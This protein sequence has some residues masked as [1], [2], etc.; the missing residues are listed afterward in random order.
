M[1][2]PEGVDTT[3]LAERLHAEGVLIE[4]GRP[5]LPPRGGMPRHY[6]LAYSSIPA[7]RIGEG[8]PFWPTRLLKGLVWALG[9]QNWPY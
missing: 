6:R 7:A 2:A 3:E 1:H 9:G 8:R 4:P 5:S